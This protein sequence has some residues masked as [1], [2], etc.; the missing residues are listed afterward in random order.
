MI[1]VNNEKYPIPT[2]I[3]R[4]SFDEAYEKIISEESFGT[5]AAINFESKLLI[6]N[7]YNGEV[8]LN[9]DTIDDL[10]SVII[11]PNFSQSELSDLDFVKSVHW[12]INCLSD[13]GMY[14]SN[15]LYY[16]S[17]MSC[18]D[19][20]DQYQLNL[21]TMINNQYKY[22]EFYSKFMFSET[23]NFYKHFILYS[24]IEFKVKITLYFLIHMITFLIYIFI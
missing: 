18:S 17:F 22:F 16:R 2:K 23:K 11:I 7:R 4:D 8:I 10:N 15:Q 20:Y 21:E 6:I 5:R 14:R 9:I 13:I 1:E 19:I 24:S 3:D 12:H